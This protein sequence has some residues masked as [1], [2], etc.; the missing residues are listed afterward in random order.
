VAFLKAIG[1][2]G[3]HQYTDAKFSSFWPTECENL[4]TTATLGVTEECFSSLYV[5][6]RTEQMLSEDFKAVFPVRTRAIHP[7][8][9]SP[10]R[11]MTH[12]GCG[13]AVVSTCVCASE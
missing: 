5:K 4:G 10:F 13:N 9:P 1:S 3:K 2:W 11:V 7:P 8:T 6:Y 12:R